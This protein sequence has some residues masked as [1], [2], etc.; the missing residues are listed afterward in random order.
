MNKLISIS[1]LAGCLL[2]LDA[3]PAVADNEARNRHQPRVQQHSRSYDNNKHR[4]NKHYRDAYRRAYSRDR[5]Y[6]LQQSW[7][8]SHM[9]NWL[10]NERSFRRW[11]RHSSLRHNRHLSWHVLFDIYRWEYSRHHDYRY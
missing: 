1:M 5:H 9:P 10:R 2:L 7:R 3:A 6:R 11:Y 8:R 4:H